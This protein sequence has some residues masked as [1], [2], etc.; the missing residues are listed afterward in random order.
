[1]STQNKKVIQIPLDVADYRVIY[2][3]AKKRRLPTSTFCKLRIF[4]S[5]EDCNSNQNNVTDSV[6]STE[7][8]PVNKKER[9][10]VINEYISNNVKF[11]K[12][13]LAERFG[14]TRSTIYQDIKSIDEYKEILS[15]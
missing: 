4:E 13:L 5:I 14:V 2:N 8:N 6:E 3:E 12:T 9:M 10:R 1:M 15:I 11:N 7:L